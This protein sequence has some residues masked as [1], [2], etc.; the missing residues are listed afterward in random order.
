MKRL[1]RFML[2]AFVF[3]LCGQL[4]VAAGPPPAGNGLL[5][6]TAGPVVQPRTCIRHSSARGADVACRGPVEQS[7]HALLTSIKLPANPVPYGSAV[8]ISAEFS[9]PNTGEQHRATIAWGDGS[10]TDVNEA[11][12]LVQ[13]SHRYAAG[14][15]T[16]GVGVTN[17]EWAD[18][19]SSSV[20]QT[21]YVVVYD[22]AAPYVTGNGWLESGTRWCPVEDACTVG[23]GVAQFGFVVGYQNGARAPIGRA[24]IRFQ[25]GGFRFQSM[26]HDRLIISGD[27]AQLRGS[28]WVNGVAGY[29][30]LFAV[31]DGQRVGH[32]RNDRLGIRVWEK[33]SGRVVYD[34][35]RAKIEGGQ[36]TIR[37]SPLQVDG[38]GR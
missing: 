15:Y 3:F 27:A 23:N 25:D 11:G 22:A 35:G 33:A 28:G 29:E 24:D 32:S 1:S 36:I 19:R 31:H 6:A 17:G 7:R 12:N 10:T 16:V 13:R 20:E 8:D 30:F 2:F 38:S 26:T 4:R 14:V 37:K 21:S 18:C 9:A 5:C 34:N